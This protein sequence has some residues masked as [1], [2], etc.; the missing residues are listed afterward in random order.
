M[1][2]FLNAVKLD[3]CQDFRFRKMD[4]PHNPDSRLNR[5]FR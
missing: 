4:A 2:D 5:A 3:I 1:L